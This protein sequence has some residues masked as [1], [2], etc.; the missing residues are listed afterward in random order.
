MGLASASQTWGT[1]QGRGHTPLL[2][3]GTSCHRTICFLLNPCSDGGA[4]GSP[5][6]AMRP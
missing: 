5:V 1:C 6:L 3:Q 4:G 2:V